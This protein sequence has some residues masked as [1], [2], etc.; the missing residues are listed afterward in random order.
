MRRL[1]WVAATA[2][3]ERCLEGAVC[4]GQLEL[5]GK[6]REVK[7]QRQT[8]VTAQASDINTDS[9]QLRLGSTTGPLKNPGS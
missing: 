3:K 9:T 5:E 4:S 1:E 8:H 6:S 2:A 7:Q